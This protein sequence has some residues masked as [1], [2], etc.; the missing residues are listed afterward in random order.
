MTDALPPTTPEEE[1]AALVAWLQARQA[2]IEIDMD[3]FLHVDLNP[4]VSIRDHAEADALARA[5]FAVRSEI[6]IILLSRGT[7]H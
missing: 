3:G 5:I 4:V 2:V 7:V 1:A 6:K